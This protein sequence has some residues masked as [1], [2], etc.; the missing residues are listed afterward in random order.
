[1]FDRSGWQKRYREKHRARLKARASEL[2][3][4]N[5]EKRNSYMRSWTAKNRDKRHKYGVKARLK[6]KY[7]LIQGDYEAMLAAQGGHC[8]LCD[9]TPDQERYKRLNIDHCHETG[10]IRG[11]LCTPHNHALGKMGDTEEALLRALAYIRGSHA[12]KKQGGR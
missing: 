12:Y 10:M 8:A 6:H 1:M 9:T 5:K 7:G 11:L 3:S 4:Q 2:H